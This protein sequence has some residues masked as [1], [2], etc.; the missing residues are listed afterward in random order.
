MPFVN[1]FDL[2]EPQNSQPA[3]VIGTYILEQTKLSLDERY[4]LEHQGLN[5][6]NKEPNTSTAEGRHIPGAVGVLF[7]GPRSSFPASPT[8][9]QIA[10]ATDEPNVGFY[11]NIA[12]AWT[13]LA[14]STDEYV[15]DNATLEI[16]AGSPNQLAMK[17]DH[18]QW[19]TT[20]VLDDAIS[21]L[22]DCDESN[23]F[24]VTLGNDRELANPTH[25]ETGATYVWIIKQDAT[26]GRILTYGTAF[27][28]AGGLA[29]VLSTDPHAKDIITAIYDGT[30]LLASA[31]YDFS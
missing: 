10:Y 20:A 15:T 14:L 17:H 4:S 21:I 24:S 26:G 9:G 8:G 28:W 29:P 13:S 30:N 27:K 25:M 5:S 22:T 19:T 16:V 11:H 31:L 2:S 6:G 23:S 1:Q 12:G 18:Q 3:N 7:Y